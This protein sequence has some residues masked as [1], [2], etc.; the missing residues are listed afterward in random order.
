MEILQ[1]RY[2]NN[3]V[4]IKEI[5]LYIM[6]IVWNAQLDNK[7]LKGIKTFDTEKKRYEVKMEV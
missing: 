3:D 7:L 1:W 4:M 6:S 2:S 5:R